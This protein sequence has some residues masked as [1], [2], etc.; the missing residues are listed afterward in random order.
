MGWQLGR[1][2]PWS[3]LETQ[4]D[5]APGARVGQGLAL[6]KTSS[7][8][9]GVTWEHG[10][11]TA[12]LCSTPVLL[13]AWVL[14]RALRSVCRANEWLEGAPPP[15]S[16]RSLHKDVTLSGGSGAVSRPT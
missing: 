16:P 9:L 12:W 8:G 15:G 4:W 7:L 14:G 2:P 13:Q 11:T 5:R 1:P 3:E 10:D 6:W